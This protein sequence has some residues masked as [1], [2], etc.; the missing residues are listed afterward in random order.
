MIEFGDGLL[1]CPG[2]PNLAFP[3]HLLLIKFQVP[4]RSALARYGWNEKVLIMAFYQ[5]FHPIKQARIR[6]VLFY[7]CAICTHVAKSNLLSCTC[8]HSET[9][10]VGGN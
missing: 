4:L 8:L 7:E 1:E 2:L 10:S 3:R 6:K 9:Q 5:W